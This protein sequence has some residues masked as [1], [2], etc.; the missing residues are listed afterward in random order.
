MQPPRAKRRVLVLAY[1]FPPMGLSGV[2]RIAKFVKYLP[3][4]GWEP[5]VLTVDPSGYFAFDASLA[6]EMDALGISV[7]RT[8]SLDP[9]RLFGQQATVALPR[10]EKRRRLDGISQAL[11]IPDNKIGWFPFAVAA[12]VRAH[13]SQPFDAVLSTA[14]PYTCH[15]IGAVLAKLLALPLVLDFRDD[16][17]GN[18]RH[19]YATRVHRRV[20]QWLESWVLRQ[21]HRAITINPVI[22][23]ALRA[24]NGGA[25][26]S[27]DVHLLPQGFDPAD[28]APATDT[29]PDGTFRLLYTGIFYDVQTPDFFLR[30][31]QA[32]RADP[33]YADV[34]LLAQFVGL[35]PDA[36]KALAAA[37]G[38]ADA[39]DFVGY[40]DHNVV[41]RYL[42]EATALWMMIGRGGD[43]ISTGK[44][45]EYIGTGKPILGMVPDG[46]ARDTLAAYGAAYVTPPDDVPA[47][48]AALKRM[49]DAWRA[50]RWPCVSQEYVQQFNRRTLTQQL[51]A[52]LDTGVSES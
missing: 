42:H 37:L 6:A 4:F 13:R 51:A 44:L 40:Q 29:D 45:Y 31:L 52:I 2:Q 14:P 17:V 48:T 19:R 9:T 30:A 22:Q 36:S 11:F 10:E 26:A 1:Y 39:V 21:A 25:A 8:R 24:R 5:V 41:I 16:W 50:G 33:N 35:V 27:T 12:A 34:P 23:Q 28:M 18:P 43:N 38:L 20:H 46:P 47:I 3:E 32:L 15:L 7:I 49:V